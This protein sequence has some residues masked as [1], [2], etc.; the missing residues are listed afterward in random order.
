M[1]PAALE[2]AAQEQARL[3]AAARN[4]FMERGIGPVDV[5]AVALALRLPEATVAV[6]FPAG[7]PALVAAVTARYL[8]GFRAQLAEHGPASSTAVEEMLRVRR[9]LQA[10][11]DEMRSLF[12][13]ELAAD[14]PAQYQQLRAGRARW[15]QKVSQAA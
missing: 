4:L 12:V 11:P 7:K 1:P 3:V 6:H 5:P 13:R 14:Y 9:T 15:F 2:F 8:A 10:L